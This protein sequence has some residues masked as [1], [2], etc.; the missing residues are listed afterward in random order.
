MFQETDRMR[1]HTWQLFLEIRRIQTEL[2]EELGW[3]GNGERG[4]PEP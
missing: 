2:L 4:G 1:T 3:R